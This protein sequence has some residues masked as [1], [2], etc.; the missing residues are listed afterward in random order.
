MANG[1][2]KQ[3]KGIIKAAIVPTFHFR[4]K[5]PAVPS[6]TNIASMQHVAVVEGCTILQYLTFAY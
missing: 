5:A 2:S 3:S 6:Q 4:R 1:T